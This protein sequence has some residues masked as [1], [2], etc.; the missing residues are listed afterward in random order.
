VDGQEIPKQA[1]TGF[2]SGTLS[3]EWLIRVVFIIPNADF[4]ILIPV[5]SVPRLNNIGVFYPEKNPGPAD[6]GLMNHHRNAKAGRERGV[7]SPRAPMI[8]CERRKPKAGMWSL[9]AKNEI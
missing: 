5:K 7:K 3:P 2:Y 6:M 1:K 4:S 9:W 8:T